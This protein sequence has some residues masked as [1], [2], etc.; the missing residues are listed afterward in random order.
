MMSRWLILLCFIPALSVLAKTPP[1]LQSIDLKAQDAILVSRSDGGVEFAWQADKALIPASLTKLLTTHLVLQK[2]GGDYRFQT[3]FYQSS[4]TLWVKGYG[5]PMLISEEFDRLVQVLGPKLDRIER[6]AIDA[7]WFID[8]ASPGRSLVSDPYN[9]PLSAV[10]ANFNTVFIERDGK[11]IKSAEA[12]TPITPLVTTLASGLRASKERINLVSGD[13]A[14]R[15]FAELL[16]AKLGFNQLEIDINQRVPAGAKLVYRHKNSTDLRSILQAALLYS[17]NFISNQLFINLGAQGDS[18]SVSF[19]AA[20]Q[21]VK[22]TLQQQFAWRHFT[23]EEGAGLSRANRLSA[24][25]ID[26]VLIQ[27]QPNKDLLEKVATDNPDIEVYAKT[28]TLDGVRSYAGFIE[29]NDFSPSQQYRFVFLFNRQVPYRY[30]DTVLK[31]LIKDLK[32]QAASASKH[33]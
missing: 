3:E 25:Q 5:D 21:H 10:S 12:Q 23:I 20:Q 13:N 24:Q 16:V 19:A 30:R 27:L 17:N 8:E 28:G 26:S 11:T 14:Q 18:Q 9:A 32:K 31:E 33:R 6:I 4:N 29:M 2:W 15:Y 7:S 22:S 1:L